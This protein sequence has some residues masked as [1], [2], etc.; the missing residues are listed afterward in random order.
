MRHHSDLLLTSR[1]NWWSVE[2]YI[3]VMLQKT[4][5]CLQRVICSIFIVPT[6]PVLVHSCY[7]HHHKERHNLRLF[8]GIQ[9]SNKHKANRNTHI[10]E[11]KFSRLRAKK[12][13]NIELP[14]DDIKTKRQK[15]SP[16]DLRLILLKKGINPY[17]DVT[18]QT[19]KEFQ[20]TFNSCYQVM[21]PFVPREE[22]SPNDPYTIFRKNPLKLLGF[23]FLLPPEFHEKKE[24]LEYALLRAEEGRFTAYQHKY[25]NRKHGIKRI[26]KR[27]GF[28]NF[29]IKTFPATADEIYVEAHKALM[30]RDKIALQKYITETAFGKMWPDVE[31]GSVVWE[32]M[33]HI[34]LSRVVSVRCAD[35]PHQSGNDIAQ[36]IVRMHTMQK[37]ALYDRFG[38]LILGTEHEAKPVLEYV[39]FENHIASFDG[40]W[41]LHDKV[42]PEWIKPKRDVPRQTKISQEHLRI[43][44][45]RPLKLGGELELNC[46]ITTA[47]DFTMTEG[48]NK[49]KP[50]G[51]QQKMET[52]IE[53][54]DEFEEF[55][56]QDWQAKEGA[57]DEEELNVWEDNW[58]DEANEND[59]AKQLRDEL[60]K[61]GHGTA[62]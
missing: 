24:S 47:K 52:H 16:L 46:K 45:R 42:Y 31:N 33:K 19:W 59:F 62:T 5:S 54:D 57:E 29:S 60:A 44:I 55:P 6:S 1:L 23:P 43:Q 4:Y 9:R 13:F 22:S 20:V 15:M 2:Y 27:K 56:Q 32:L 38:R 17:R 58:D 50:E 53:E 36:I 14:D 35:F 25:F 61:H 37:I 10:N 34:E 7:V 48:K 8:L 41:R 3:I 28:E 39:V 11:R 40:V 51:N 21:D 30:T 26:R 18:P 12:N 49:S